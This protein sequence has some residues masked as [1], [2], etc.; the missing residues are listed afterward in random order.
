MNN[1]KAFKQS[2][3]VKFW[4]FR[5]RKRE[6]ECW[7]LGNVGLWSLLWWNTEALCP[8]RYP[9][10]EEDANYFNPFY[11]WDHLQLRNPCTKKWLKHRC[12]W[13]KTIRKNAIKLKIHATPRD[14][15]QENRKRINQIRMIS[16]PNRREIS[17]SRPTIN[18]E[19][20]KTN[21]T[22]YTS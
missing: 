16:Y 2:N 15:K 14:L 13:K 21:N 7:K 19:K 8:Q 17:P 9:E 5:R 18:Q 3:Q 12:C 10:D 11:K 1:I 6:K 4:F 22:D 20:T